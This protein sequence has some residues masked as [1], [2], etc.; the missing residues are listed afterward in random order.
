MKKIKKIKYGFLSIISVLLTLFF[1]VP[2]IA[3]SSGFPRLEITEPDTPSQ[4]DTEVSEYYIS[5]EQGVNYE[6]HVWAVSGSYLAVKGFLEEGFDLS[7]FSEYILLVEPAGQ[8]D[9]YSLA[10]VY[11]HIGFENMQPSTTDPD[12]MYLGSGGGEVSFERWFK[13]HSYKN[14]PTFRNGKPALPP[15]DDAA[16][17]DIHVDS[18]DCTFADTDNQ[19]GRP[20]PEV[21]IRSDDGTVLEEG[22]DYALEFSDV[23]VIG[24]NNKITISHIA[25]SEKCG[26][27][28]NK[29]QRKYTIGYADIADYYILENVPDQIYSATFAGLPELKSS[30][31]GHMTESGLEQQGAAYLKEKHGAGGL[32]QISDRTNAELWNGRFLNICYIVNGT[33]YK[34]WSDCQKAW[35]KNPTEFITVKV[36]PKSSSSL[37]PNYYEETLSHSTLVE[38]RLTG[39][40]SKTVR[41]LPYSLTETDASKYPPTQMYEDTALFVCTNPQIKETDVPPF[42]RSVSNGSIQSVTYT[43]KKVIPKFTIGVY[44][45]ARNDLSGS[46]PHFVAWDLISETKPD[47]PKIQAV[48]KS[49]S[50]ENNVN[51]G[52]GTIRID[53]KFPYAGTITRK[54]TIV[55]KN[56]ADGSIK[57][58]VENPVYTGKELLPNVTVTDEQR[59]VVLK[60]GTDYTLTGAQAEPGEG[61]AVI[62]GIGNYTGKRFASYTVSS[63]A[64]SNEAV[65]EVKAEKVT[66]NGKAQLPKVTVKDK[67]ANR[68]LTQDVDY[69]LEA[70]VKAD[71][72]NAGEGGVRVIGITMGG[73]IEKSFVIEPKMLDDSIEILPEKTIYNGRPLLPVVKATDTALGQ[74]LQE[75]VDFFVSAEKET[76]NVNIGTGKAVLTGIGN[77][78]GTKTFTFAIEENAGSAAGEENVIST[79]PFV[80]TERAKNS[81]R[82]MWGKQ[83]GS[84]G[85]QVYMSTKANGKYK[86]VAQTKGKRRAEI[87]KLKTG[88]TYYFKVRSFK[89]VKGK[90]VYQPFSRPMAICTRLETP[91]ITAVQSTK[92]G[93][94]SVRWKRD[95]K[96][97][98]YQIFVKND[99]EGFK[100]AKEILNNKK[101]SGS[102]KKMPSRSEAVVRIRSYIF[103]DGKK[104]YSPYSSKVKIR[105][106]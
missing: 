32:P 17:W 23:P 87:K 18:S 52:T 86:R 26:A 71:N 4:I 76:D 78:T 75:S 73:S 95:K 70:A 14:L 72:V 24:P 100:L 62:T 38:K 2:A 60:E 47:D 35:R 12:I 92:K 104:Y 50:Y 10:G 96:A 53:F 81:L 59:N 44:E 90:K 83:K 85:Y 42:D 3:G 40:I 98:G 29:I 89:K 79:K 57:V 31:E 106:R 6:R 5:D 21:T 8:E 28:K 77:Y 88:T 63:S 54:F 37:D 33:E 48:I 64:L 51:A 11:Y 25:D 34:N 105:V 102:I 36:S 74:T 7:D 94:V 49:I 61:T 22:R 13:D 67:G 82:L 68:I 65:Y 56:I 9:I 101:T 58:E 84:D 97:D 30:Q 80:V 99:K 20:V 41:I 55:Q 66:Y 19:H 91:E 69:R 16:Y 103:A 1:A 45:Y 43:G 15:L 46:S 39:S 93:T 27:P